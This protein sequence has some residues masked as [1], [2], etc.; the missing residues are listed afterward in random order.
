MLNLPLPGGSLRTYV[1]SVARP[2]AP[3][4]VSVNRRPLLAVALLLLLPSAALAQVFVYPR[5]ADRSQVTTFDFEWRHVDIL[6]GPAAQGLAK[7]PERTAN[8]QPPG[9]PAG[10]NPNV[11]TLSPGSSATTVPTEGP[12]KTQSTSTPSEGGVAVA[13]AGSPDGGVPGA[14]GGVPSGDGGVTASEFGHMAFEPPP[15]PTAAASPDAGMSPDG[16][17]KYATTLGPTTGGVRFYFYER[18]RQV[19]ERAA[20]L[21][22]DSYRYLVEPVPLRPHGDV[23]LHPLQ[24][25]PGVPADAR[26]RRLGGHARR[27]QHRGPEALAAVPGGPPALPGDQHARAVA[28]VHHPEGAHHRGEQEDVRRS[29]AGHA[30][31]VRRRS[32]RV[33]RQARVGPRGGDARAGSDGEPGSGEGL[34][35]PRLLLPWA[36]RLPVDLQGR[37]G[38]VRLP[39]GGVRRGLHPAGAGGVAPAHLGRPGYAVREVRGSA[40]EAHRRR[41]EDDLRPLRD[42]DEAARLQGLPELRAVRAGAGAA[43]GARGHRHGDEQ[44][45]G[46]AVD[47]LPHHHPGHGREPAVPGGSQGP[48]QLD[49]GG[50]RRSARRRVAAPHLRAQLRAVEGSAR[51]RGGGERAGRDLRAEL[52]VHRRAE[53]R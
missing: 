36:L 24:Q 8:P 21:I 9:A 2:P 22:E 13:S 7:P 33:L 25:L 52:H 3:E 48:E 1:R 12:P 51:L 32:G 38:A 53:D 50:A 45:A 34:R 4:V 16:G 42:L 30:A 18:E 40:E 23:P 26:V 28:P 20:P 6:V 41:S 17:P 10:P 49:P 5:R 31:V 37:P 39:G 43:G 47:L 15:P 14:D 27:H 44:L 46:R 19:A 11:T 35:V 29:A